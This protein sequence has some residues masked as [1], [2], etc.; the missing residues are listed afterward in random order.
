MGFG[1]QRWGFQVV[2]NEDGST[3]I[4]TD[5]LR[6][7]KYSGRIINVHCSSCLLIVA[8]IGSTFL[9]NLKLCK[10]KI[11]KNKKEKVKTVN[12]GSNQAMRPIVTK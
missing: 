8:Y 11:N 9:I 6:F 5:F 2:E 12:R 3:A 7:E 1:F 10:E 4:F